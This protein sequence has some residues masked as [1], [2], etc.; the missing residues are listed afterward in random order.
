[1]ERAWI[2][3]E[4]GRKL[5]RVT[6][7]PADQ[8]RGA[9]LVITGFGE[10]SGRYEHVLRHWAAAGLLVSVHDHQGHGR[11]DGT[12]GDVQRFADYVDDAEAA[13]RVLSADPRASEQGPPII[14]AH[15]MG[16]LIATH[17]LARG[18][19]VRGLALSSPFYALALKKPAWLKGLARG[20]CK[21]WPTFRQS[22]DIRGAQLTH[23]PARARAIDTD[24]MQISSVTA[25]WFVE[26]EAAQAGLAM[27]IP[28]V[29]SPVFC[30]AAGEDKLVDVVATREL[31]GGF[32]SLQKS[33]EVLPGQFHELHQEQQRD[34]I[35][36]R[37]LEQFERWC[38]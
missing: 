16:G 36:T 29:T 22:T 13:L 20:L 6:L 21:V 3:R 27:V 28:Q 23:D 24:P 10:H 14:F 18:H 17:L 4:N 7:S 2:E 34:S 33:L 32:P 19:R 12:P 1:M 35:L 26:I 31:F 38:S 37:Y 9:V 15:S 11:S 5:R 25:R 30:L 8:A